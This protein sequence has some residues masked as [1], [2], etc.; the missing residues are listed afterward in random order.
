MYILA[1]MLA[2][3]LVAN[4]L[5]RPLSDKWFM[6]DDEV[7]ALQAK[8]AAAN[9]GPTGSFGIGTGGL[10]AKAVLAWAVVGIPYVEGDLRAVRLTYRKRAA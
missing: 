7:A 2:L 10:D 4:A 8:S 6:S 9:A 5:I 1:G 3:G